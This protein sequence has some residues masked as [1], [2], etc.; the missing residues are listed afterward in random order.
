MS[1]RIFQLQQDALCIS[2]W[3]GIPFTRSMSS[4]Q[5]GSS[6][7]CSHR[8][9]IFSAA[10]LRVI[11]RLPASQQHP[12]QQAAG[13]SQL[14]QQQVLHTILSR[15]PRSLFLSSKAL[16]EPSYRAK[17]DFSTASA[18]AVRHSAHAQA[19][20]SRPTVQSC[21]RKLASAATA[22]HRSLP[23]AEVKQDDFQW[24]CRQLRLNVHQS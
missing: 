11:S 12:R 15:Q 7:T 23:A 22:G 21:T 18:V 17:F 10:A 24:K 5:Q 20:R 3:P 16:A 13:P 19:S 8:Q 2:H 6:P 1:R 9:Y 14:W 4:L